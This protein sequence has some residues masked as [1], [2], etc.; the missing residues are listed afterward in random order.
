MLNGLAHINGTLRGFGKG[1]GAQK[2]HLLAQ[3]HVQTTQ[4]V[5]Q[6]RAITLD[7]DTKLVS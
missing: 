5:M 4:V 7:I 1:G 6:T 3:R 2:V